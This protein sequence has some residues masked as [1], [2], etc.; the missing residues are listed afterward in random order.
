MKI[1]HSDFTWA[2]YN[3]FYTQTS[4]T[5][6]TIFPIVFFHIFWFKVIYSNF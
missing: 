2:K 4:N 3:I 6:K 1:K 5:L